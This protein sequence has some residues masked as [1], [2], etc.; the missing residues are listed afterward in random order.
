MK[1]FIISILFI[2]YACLTSANNWQDSLKPSKD[3]SYPNPRKALI[4]S[5]ILPGYGQI[6]NQKYWKLPIIYGGFAGLGGMLWFNSA[7]MNR[8]QNALVYRLDED[9]TTIDTEFSG[10]TLQAVRSN[11]D[12]YRRWRDIAIVSMVGLYA[13]QVID[14]FVDAHLYEFRVNKDLQLSLYPT[15]QGLGLCYRF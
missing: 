5:A 11:R 1:L 7:Q 14:A 15:N 3:T 2:H 9:P 10:L 13:L 12:F 4:K 6:Y 8:Y